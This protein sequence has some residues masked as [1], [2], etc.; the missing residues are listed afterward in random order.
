MAKFLDYT[1]LRSEKT[2][3]YSLFLKVEPTLLEKELD[4]TINE[5]KQLV[6]DVKDHESFVSEQLRDEIYHVLNNQ[7]VFTL[8]VDKDANILANHHLSLMKKQKKV[9]P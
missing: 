2:G 9:K 4:I 1:Y 5:L 6:I 3:K 7:E 8:F